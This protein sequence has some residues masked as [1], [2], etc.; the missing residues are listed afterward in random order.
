MSATASLS[1]RMRTAV[2][3][4][5]LLLMLAMAWHAGGFRAGADLFPRIMGTVGV[6]LCV[7]ELLRQAVVRWR[8]AAD[9]SLSTADLSLDPEDHTWAGYRRSLVLFGW[10]LG[11]YALIAV[12]GMPVATLVF[13]PA[14]LVGRFQARWSVS[15]G[16]AV[17]LVLLMVLLNRSL[18]LRWPSGWMPWPW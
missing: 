5:L 9:G 1:R 15:M 12:L 3:A 2:I 16:L 10:L 7:I 18:Q 11:Y 13:V 14:L 6:L 8:P 17:G 4:L